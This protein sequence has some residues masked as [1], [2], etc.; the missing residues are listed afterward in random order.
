MSRC[1]ASD[2]RKRSDGCSAYISERQHERILRGPRTCRADHARQPREAYLL[3]G[4][5]GCGGVALYE[6]GF[7]EYSPFS[8][9]NAVAVAPGGRLDLA[10]VSGDGLATFRYWPRAL[11]KVGRSI[12]RSVPAATW[13]TRREWPRTIPCPG[14]QYANAALAD[15]GLSV[16]SGAVDDL[17]W[18][19][20][21]RL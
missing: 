9:L 11:T 16:Q 6:L 13:S 1:P 14:S 2:E 8:E 21:V 4:I 3:A 18:R 20:R 15:R 5:A 17:R 7:G 19:H 10:G 12:R